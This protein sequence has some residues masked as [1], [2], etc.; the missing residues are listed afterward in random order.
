[1]YFPRVTLH[2]LCQAL[3]VVTP[4]ARAGPAAM[5]T[6]ETGGEHT[7]A[8]ATAVKADAGRKTTR[9]GEKPVAGAAVPVGLGAAVWAGWR[10]RVQAGQ[11]ERVQRRGMWSGHATRGLVSRGHQERRAAGTSST[12]DDP[13]RHGPERAL[14]SGWGQR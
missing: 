14:C 4:E 8:P 5:R 10:T 6:E 1:M 2:A 9:R 3:G 13:V 11:R 12:R 7:G